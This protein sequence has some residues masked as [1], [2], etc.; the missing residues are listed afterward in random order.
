MSVKEARAA[1]RL[2]GSLVMTVLPPSGMGRAR[3]RPFQSYAAQEPPARD[4]SRK[5]AMGIPYVATRRG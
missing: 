5:A 1:V 2:A 3:R 4:V